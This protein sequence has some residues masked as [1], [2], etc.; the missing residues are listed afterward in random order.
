MDFYRLLMQAWPRVLRNHGAPGADGV[1]VAGFGEDL[2]CHLVALAGEI[3]AGVYRTGQLRKAVI[4]HGGK[5]REIV[6]LNVRDR[7]VH[8]MMAQY[9]SPRVEA[10]LPDCCFSYRSNKSALL[11]IERVKKHIKDGAAWVAE[12]DIEHFFDNIEHEALAAM[13]ESFISDEAVRVLLRDMLR[14]IKPQSMGFFLPEKGAIQGSPAS[15]VLSNIYLL[16]IDTLM[17]SLG[18]CFIRYCDDFVVLTK[19]EEEAKKAMDI[20]A[21]ELAALGLKLKTSKTSVKQ[22]KD[23]FVFLGYSFN[24]GKAIPGPGAAKAL[25]SRLDECGP[26]KA[27]Q[28]LRGWDNYYSLEYAASLVQEEN[29]RSIIGEYAKATGNKKLEES[30]LMNE[31]NQELSG[32]DVLMLTRI[33]EGDEESIEEAVTLCEKYLDEGNFR[34]AQVFGD[35]LRRANAGRSNKPDMAAKVETPVSPIKEDFYKSFISLFSGR[36]NMYAIETIDADGI[37]EYGT[38]EGYI[39]REELNAHINGE[40][41]LAIYLHRINNTVRCLVI[42]LDVAKKAILD[43]GGIVPEDKLE[44]LHKYAVKVSKEAGN[45]GL[46]SFIEDSGYRG[47]HLWFF[48]NEA[49]PA[50]TAIELA[51][52]L[53]DRAGPL[54]EGVNREVFPSKEKLKP[55]Q[56]GNKIKLPFG[57][58]LR[59]GRKCNFLN[60]AGNELG[61]YE[62]VVKELLYTDITKV[63]GFL[64]GIVQEPIQAEE[65]KLDAEKIFMTMAQKFP[66]AGKIISRCRLVHHLVRKSVF[67]NYLSHFER[68][69]LLHTIGH[70]G[71]EGKIAIHDVIGKC[72]NYKPHITEKFIAKILPKP[73]SCPRLREDYRELTAQLGCDCRLHVPPG[74]YPSPV[75]HANKSATAGQAMKPV[76]QELSKEG[77]EEV[78]I[79]KLTEKLLNIRKQ[80]KQM[81][82]ALAKV[83]EGFSAIMDKKGMDTLDIEI[84]QL[85]RRK[86]SGGTEEWVIE[87]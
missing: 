86:N 79:V 52:K 16:P 35:A 49:L 25:F 33:S 28:V 70:A 31:K 80:Q 57:I 58:N 66:D 11:A 71:D 85:I 30:L 47:R 76:F 50:A 64:T 5:E 23:G 62:N 46:Y 1:T 10:Y 65:V 22:I 34:M 36:E 69:T 19:T 32:A 73:V 78:V 26:D 45:A 56:I 13:A 72:I 55:A 3:E 87:L 61:D 84:G 18:Y 12:S 63:R 43:N 53:L 29:H 9:L 15:P 24:S 17:K 83:Y 21:G 20:I 6:I 44:Q 81:E 60:A 8:Q 2:E 68:L 37:R 41:V 14:Q 54:P 27:F 48:F 7:V 77:D 38:V 82:K 59:T 51:N 39:S 67:T 42:D 74:G 4:R 75:L 40:K